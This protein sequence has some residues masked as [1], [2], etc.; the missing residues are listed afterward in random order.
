VIAQDRD[1]QNVGKIFFKFHCALAHCF[2]QFYKKMDK[3]LFSLIFIPSYKPSFVYS[4]WA[5]VSPAQIIK[6]G[7]GNCFWAWPS[8]Y[9]TNCWKQGV[10]YECAY[11]VYNEFEV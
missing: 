9:S 6:S 3:N 11:S 5:G 7:L 1:Q 10:V 8:M 4:T 2:E